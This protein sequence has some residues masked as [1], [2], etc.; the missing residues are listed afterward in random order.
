MKIAVVLTLALCLPAVISAFNCGG[1]SVDGYWRAFRSEVINNDEQ[2]VA[3]MYDGQVEWR[4]EWAQFMSDWAN[5]NDTESQGNRDIARQSCK[6]AIPDRVYNFRFERSIDGDDYR[7]EYYI[8]RGFQPSS[9]AWDR[10]CRILIDD[11]LPVFVESLGRSVNKLKGAWVRSSKGLMLNFGGS[12]CNA[13]LK[14]R[15]IEQSCLMKNDANRYP[16]EIFCSG[17]QAGVN[18]LTDQHAY[19]G[20]HTHARYGCMQYTWDSDT[21]DDNIDENWGNSR[22]DKMYFV[23]SYNGQQNFKLAQLFTGSMSLNR[24]VSV[25]TPMDLCEVRVGATGWS[26]LTGVSDHPCQ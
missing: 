12:N 2:L 21:N 25:D 23:N 3:Q 5:L 18:A 22:C 13:N 16:T 24:L 10:Y 8:H 15:N 17:A 19:G 9:Q 7:V 6:E 11:D 26:G 1:C 14:P 4:E 20:A